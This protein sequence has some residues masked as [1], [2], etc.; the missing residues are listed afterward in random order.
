MAC[1]GRRVGLEPPR[2]QTPGVL[3]PVYRDGKLVSYYVLLLEQG[4]HIST[5]QTLLF[6]QQHAT[7]RPCVKNANLLAHIVLYVLA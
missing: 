3:R 5:V 7:P 6:S 2:P 4:E 1:Q